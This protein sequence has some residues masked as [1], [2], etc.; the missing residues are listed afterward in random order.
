MEW[1][2]ANGVVVPH[3]PVLRMVCYAMRC[4]ALCAMCFA[5]H[6]SH[7][8]HPFGY[9]RLLV[10]QI[11]VTRFSFAFGGLAFVFFQNAN[12]GGTESIKDHTQAPLETH[13]STL[14]HPPSKRNPLKT[15][16]P[17]NPTVLVN[18][19]LDFDLNKLYCE[20]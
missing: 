7:H 15:E 17:T 16:G 19:A 11:C 12:N 9:L 1:L 20:R 6:P 18:N 2:K 8:Y 10:S 13:R 4:D 14:V 3:F 5:D